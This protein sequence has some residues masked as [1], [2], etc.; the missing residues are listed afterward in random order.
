[1]RKSV[2]AKPITSLILLE[3]V[4]KACADRTRLRLLYLM[5]IEG[6][7]CV[8]NFVTV[9]QT[10]Q[11]KV[12]RHLSYL[13]RAGLV[14]D[15]KEGLWVYYSLADSAH[16]II[17]NILNCITSHCNEDSQAQKDLRKLRTLQ[18]KNQNIKM[19][20]AERQY[21]EDEKSLI[22]HNEIQIELL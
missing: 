15:R 5:A 17:V 14:I 12:S 10:N 16:Q 11:P 19:I 1:M 6:E 21:T 3:Q 7:V 13:K 4:F 8:R 18:T 20:V 2:V 22:S 9:L